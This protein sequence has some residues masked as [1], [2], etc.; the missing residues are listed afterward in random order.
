MEFLYRNYFNTTTMS[1]VSQGGTSSV[2]NL[3]DRRIGKK[4]GSGDTSDA[5]TTTISV[6]FSSAQDVD[7]IILQNINLKSFLIYYNSN[8]ANKFSVTSA[9]TGTTAW[10]TN[11][12]TSLYL[13]LAAT[14]S[15]DS[16]QIAASTTI[17]A[18]AEKQIGQFWVT[19]QY[20]EFDYD[21]TAKNYKASY[22][23]K[24]YVHTMSDGGK[25]M[26]RVDEK[27]K[28]DIKR[29]YIES[30]EHDDLKDLYDETDGFVF[31]PEPTGTSW[32]NDIWECIWIGDFDLTWTQNYKGTG[33]N[34]TV[35]LRETAK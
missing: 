11:S 32:S 18:N 10:S 1:I 22:D 16:I 14:T 3:I 28:S 8:T 24:E 21:P 12:E 31:T 5:T 2:S 15:I 29:Q 13:M 30:T 9:L 33:F 19:R 23:S 20:M 35:R 27:F 6:E 17:S 7:R 34:G 26:Y 4:F 25:S